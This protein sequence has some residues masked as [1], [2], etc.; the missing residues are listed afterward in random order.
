MV[1]GGCGLRQCAHIGLLEATVV[2]A[3]F[4]CARAGAP[5][6]PLCVINTGDAQIP[7]LH[8]QTAGIKPWAASQ[9]DQV[10]PGRRRTIRPKRSNDLLGIIAE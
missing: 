4:G 9:L 7:K 6:L 1:D 3:T 5:Q 2:Q 8:G 10:A